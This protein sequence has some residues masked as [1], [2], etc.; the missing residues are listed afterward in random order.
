MSQTQQITRKTMTAVRAARVKSKWV[1]KKRYPKQTCVGVYLSQRGRRRFVLADAV[2][3][4]EHIFNSHESA[5]A[6]GWVKI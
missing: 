4:V 2:A 5:K 6:W 3:G 1:N